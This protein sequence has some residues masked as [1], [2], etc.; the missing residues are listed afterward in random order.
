MEENHPFGEDLPLPPAR[1]FERLSQLPGY[2]WDQSIEPFHSTYNHWHISG[3]RHA[4]EH[5]LSTPVATSS[6][7]ASSGPSSLTRYSPRTEVRPSGRTLNR[8]ISVSETS[9]EISLSRA[10]QD[11]IWT[12]VI[13]RISTNVVR[14][15]REFHMLMSVVQTSDP[16]C[17]HTIRPVDLIRLPPDPGD[18]GT[19]L[20][21]IFESPGHDTLR[22]L[23][24][25]GPASFAAGAKSESNNVTP[26]EQIPLSAFFDFALGACDCL[27]I[28]HYGLK[29]VH[30]EI[31]GDAFHFG[32]DTGTVKLANIGN[33]ARSF[34]NVLSEG[35]SSVSRELGAKY[36]LQFIAPEQT[37]RMPTEPDS[38]TDIYALGLFFW[39]MLVGKLPF[40][41]SDPVDVVQNV[42]GKKLTPVSVKRMDVPDAL[43]A[44]VQRMTQKVAQDR[45]HTISAVKRDLAQIAKLLGDGDSEALNKF[46]IA[47]HDVSSFF[48]LPSRM[49]GRQR[50][51]DLII[52]VVQKILRRQKAQLAKASTQSPGTAHALASNPSGSD[53][54]GDSFELA[55]ASSDSGSFQ[56][57]PRTSSNAANY[58]LGHVDSMSTS[59]TVISAPK[60]GYST[61]VQE[62]TGSSTGMPIP[63][64]MN[65]PSHYSRSSHTTDR[66]SS[67]GTNT[68][69]QASTGA[70]PYGQSDS[71]SSY[72][73]QKSGAKLRRDGRCELITIS[74]AAGIGK[75]DLLNRVQ[76]TIRK[77]G[78]I[79]ITR[80][81]RAKRVPFEPFAKVLAS[82]LR[83]IFSEPDVTT[84]YHHS[85]RMALRPMWPTLHRVLELP[86][87]LMSPGA[88][89][90]PSSPKSSAAQHIFKDSA[91]KGE[92]AKRNSIPW[93]NKDQS[94]ADFFLSDA[95]SNHIRLMETFIEI[96]RTLCQFRLI[97]VC[98]DDLEYADDE[99][100]ELVLN[101]VRAKLPCVLILTS[102]KDEIA[103]DNVRSL[104]ESN[105]SNITHI[106]LQPL[107]ETEVMELIA[108]T[109][110]QEPN[111][112]LTPLSAV[113]QEKSQGNPFY[114]R[115]MLETCYRTNCIWYSWKDSKWLFDL[116]RIF[117]EF[118]APVYGEGLG[119]GFLTKRLQ[120]IPP[121]ARSIMVWGALLGSSFS[122]SLVQKLLTSE[123]LYSSEDDQDLD[124]TSPQNLTLVR[125]SE[126]DIVG[127]LQYLV[128]SNL[129]NP[130]KTDDEFRFGNDRLAQA[131]LSLSEGR[132]VE[133]MHFIVSQALMKYYHD[134]RSRY[135]MAHHV[136]LA[137]RIIKSHVPKRIE[138]R[139]IL[140]DAG[141]TAAQSGARPS[142]L[143][144]FRHCIALLQNQPW[145]DSKRDVYYDETLRLFIA[146]S[147]MSWSQAQHTE[148]LK[149]ID[150]VFV[151]G[152][153][154]VDKSRA[155]VVKAKIFAQ[156]G[157]HHRSMEALL[158]CLDELGVHLRAPI[159]LEE[160]DVA[161][162]KLKSYLESADL[163]SIAEKATSKDPILIT[164]GAVMAEAMSVTYWD[165]ALTF[166]RMA[167]EMM[168]IHIFRGG[169]TPI[170]IGCSHLA[171]IA[172]SRFKDV[173]FGAKLSDFSLS[174]L[175]R[176]PELWTQSRGSIAH[177]LFV[178]H[179]RIPLVSTLPSLEASLEASFTMGDPSITLISISSMAMTRLYLG[180]DMAELE[181][182][183]METPEDLPEWMQDTRGGASIITVR[184][185]ARALQGKTDFRS[186][187]GVMSD[188]EHNVIEYMAHLNANSSNVDRPRD[189]YWGLAMMPL[190]LF[191]HHDKAVQVGTQLLDTTHRL[192]SVRVSYVVYFYLAMSL[193][194]LHNDNPG[195]G[196]LDG[197]MDTVLKYKAEIDF[198]RSASDVNYGM[199]S[200]L[201][202]ALIAE[203][204][205]D[206]T[207]A[208][209]QYEAAID[210]CQVHSW[211]LE[212]ALALE[213]QGEFLV[214]RGAK[215][216]ARAL[217][218]EAT[219]AW[220][221]ISA[222]GK[223]AH[224]AEKHEWLLKTA[225]SAKTIDVG[226]QTVDSLMEIGRD[227]GPEQISDPQIIGEDERQQ[228]WIEQNG[229]TAG[230][231]SMDISSVGLDIIDLSSILD[232]SQVMSSELQVDKLFMKM[233]EI[234]LESCNGA[235]FAAI[236]TDFEN[237]FAIAATNDVEKGQKSYADG[238]PFSDMEDKMAQ[239][240]SQ[241]VIRTKEEVLVHNVLEDERFSNVDDAYTANFPM[242]R[243]VI[244]LPIVQAEHLLGVIHLEGKPN[245]FTQRN[246]VVLHLLCNQMGI[247]LSN[248]LLF[249]EIRKVSAKNA[250]MIESQKRA[251]AQA[252]EAEQK[253][254]VAEAEAK[255]NVKLK[256]DAA[257][258]KSIF[259]ANISHDLRTPMN[260]V[261]GLSEL[262]KGTVLDKEQD[263]YVESIRVCADT[264]LT[265]I[266]DILDFSKLEAGKMKI[267]T[268]PLNLKETISEVV[269]ALRY[270]H[271]ERGLD[272]V[273]DLDRVPAGLV[274]LGDPVRLHQIFMNLLSNSYKFTPKGS[275]TVKA[276]VVREGKGRVRLE[277][278]VADTGIGIPD[279][280]RSRLFRPFSQAD[281]STERSYG[282]SG[283][284]LS[285]CKAIIEDV[286]GGAI[287]LEST[288][289][290]GT[291]V[292]FHLVFNKAPKK[293]A[294]KT[295]WSQD[296]TV[297]ESKEAPRPLA[298]DL[299]HIPRDQ[300]RVCIAE[301]N[302]INQKIA[303]KFVTGLGLQCEAYS[304]G[305][306]A[307][308][309]LRQRS[310]EGN[311]FHVVL[312]DV[313]MPTL[314]GY[315]ATRELRRDLDPNVNEVLV[316]AMT[317]SAIEGDR[318]KC[319]EAGMN[320]YLPKP[321]R[322]PILSELLDMYLAP[323]PSYP[324]SRLAIR[325]KGSRAS[326]GKD[327]GTP[328][329]FSSSA[330]EDYTRHSST[331]SSSTPTPST[332]TSSTPTPSTPSAEKN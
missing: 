43:S 42:L 39:S 235:D 332:P 202:E 171:M 227:A 120:E 13:A 93:L 123:F 108:S 164:I 92:P 318:E 185:V 324:R 260:G 166:Y 237:G 79:A 25:F 248:A 45:Y 230:E 60:H 28:L 38:R 211:P 17:N 193:L 176:C 52:S 225:T 74:G 179:L 72:T 290:A 151:H 138:Y 137:S 241:Y 29:T 295:P 285:I 89:Y 48:T 107:A 263:E 321:V 268:V 121:A 192:W 297:A 281:P 124:L 105:A 67:T 54:R 30:G 71:L 94:A 33:G 240:I 84:D 305:R 197:E 298:R 267:S 159:T 244:A 186:E 114:V 76:P 284:G 82:L 88:K 47:Q 296:L 282:G 32:G 27:E 173:Q 303:V 128:Q 122:F 21:A 212:E 311:P 146:T 1:L 35:W 326:I 269:R 205:N 223:A 309:A 231:R 266:N 234:I 307:V 147:E 135:A 201:L 90:R 191:G 165:D 161:Y 5:D 265:L 293:T 204:R 144:Y 115:V 184:Q 150:E 34:D 289:G 65:S 24:T 317:A 102:R 283:L 167:I 77:L 153:T 2:T 63:G 270:T 160:C 224:I 253:A 140:W 273:E 127:G 4:V 31:R 286:L 316:I 207:A 162:F 99:T 189:M 6:G 294:T 216:A 250:S 113:V 302:P 247:S 214:R 271:R 275:I 3:F 314:D 36:K 196:Y 41:G 61:S 103:S 219:A 257:K 272:T 245:W 109:M 254:K 19:L 215:R 69:S 195:H 174:L 10:E 261:I 20:V 181:A 208:I 37:G 15:E 51:H 158:T 50:E 100:L 222:N 142:A 97:T 152:K 180:Q 85:V 163:D 258:A 168:N 141:Q 116:D 210:H 112:T 233:L 14:L 279:E 178:S 328:T 59:D 96:L 306:Q 155:W 308:E 57:P 170:S 175:E 228:Q 274:V 110:H 8:R 18:T 87:Q 226:C 78:C 177:N 9:S 277:C 301:D 313:M 249:R 130:G 22:D 199:W 183:C 134:H 157:D 310:R 304:D 75:T 322:S 323:V 259:L 7:P 56:L 188:G 220:S 64:K 26:G 329:S 239:H 300:I 182:F 23:V 133:K 149:L 104:F 131:A 86:E 101:I 83:Q 98:I 331:R 156:L 55:S 206:H 288:P 287:W 139:R 119:L 238:L 145:D 106:E 95:A 194:T 169:F 125:K 58:H 49:F 46:Q 217:L 256:E 126:G 315:N 73:K 264:L 190:F 236:A 148:A 252:R 276:K 255:Y 143:W 129:L 68:N 213:L 132:N 319:L 327:A 209:Q 243:S 172:L 16:D 44:V 218:Q 136:A 232:S 203:V 118:V 80:L 154:A 280:Q 62:T 111:P 320:N 262:L 81:D 330:P 91:S 200:M 221:S 292:T 11:Q 229:V 251:L 40:E 291:T 12:P 117:T 278:S 66:D 198:A 246:V 312:M 299:T 242:G 325:E 53:G 70:N 187:Q